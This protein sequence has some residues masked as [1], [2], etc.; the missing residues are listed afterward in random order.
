MLETLQNAESIQERC[1]IVN[2]RYSTVQ[3]AV[4]FPLKK[5]PQKNKTILSEMVAKFVAKN[6]FKDYFIACFSG[7]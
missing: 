1:E 3:D 5:K 4:S 7:E 6:S 2:H